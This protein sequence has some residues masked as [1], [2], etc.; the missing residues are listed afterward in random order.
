MRKDTK[1]ERDLKSG[2]IVKA[3]EDIIGME[4]A[5]ETKRIMAELGADYTTLATISS[6]AVQEMVSEPSEA[7]KAGV[8]DIVERNGVKSTR[9]ASVDSVF[10]DLVKEGSIARD[11]IYNA[12]DSITKRFDALYRILDI[13][14]ET[15]NGDLL[16]DLMYAGVDKR[17]LEMLDSCDESLGDIG[18]NVA[19]LLNCN[20]ISTQY[21]DGAVKLVEAVYTIVGDKPADEDNLI[22]VADLLGIETVY[23]TEDS[24]HSGRTKSSTRKSAKQRALEEAERYFDS[25]GI[26]RKIDMSN[27]EQDKYEELLD[28]WKNDDSKSDTVLDRISKRRKDVYTRD[29]GRKKKVYSDDYSS[30]RPSSSSSSKKRFRV[31]ASDVFNRKRRSNGRVD[32][33]RDTREERYDDRRGDSNELIIL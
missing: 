5:S 33:S 15:K 20:N 9:K 24:K 8:L 27:R 29:T 28:S 17:D 25:L 11:N 22:E 7:F 12:L 21:L 32:D 23:D 6:S 3:V 2:S 31:S 30:D 19:S 1:R 26:S 10:T 16:E 14:A 18:T 4:I 13:L